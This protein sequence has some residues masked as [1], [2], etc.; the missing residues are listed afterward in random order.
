MYE[1]NADMRV[2]YVFLFCIF[3]GDVGMLWEAKIMSDGPLW[4]CTVTERGGG[5][6]IAADINN[7][8]LLYINSIARRGYIN[9]CQWPK[10]QNF[11][12]NY[13]AAH[14]APEV[15]LEVGLLSPFSIL[16]I[17]KQQTC[18]DYGYLKV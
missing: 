7:I 11:V 18:L 10:L 17:R 16:N 6:I 1:C 5:D 4:K 3:V 15:M 9:V 2:L 14:F 12:C 8:F 13:F